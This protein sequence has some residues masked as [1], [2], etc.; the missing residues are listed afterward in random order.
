[1]WGLGTLRLLQT[2]AYV[3]SVG[4]PLPLRTSSECANRG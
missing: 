3:I 1:M 2:A 4:T